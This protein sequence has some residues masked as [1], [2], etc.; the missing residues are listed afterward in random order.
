MAEIR[1]DLCPITEEEIEELFNSTDI[2]LVATCRTASCERAEQRLTAA[3]RA[4]AKYADLEIEAPALMGKRLRRLARECGT[5]FIRSFHDFET[6]PSSEDLS[7]IVQRCRRFGAEVVK[8]AVT[9]R[10]EEEVRR[11]MDLYGQAPEGTLLAFCMGEAGKRSRLDCLREGAPFTYAC[12]PGEPVADGQMSLEEMKA[13]LYGGFSFFDRQ[14]VTMPCSKSFAQR[15]IIAAALAEGTSRLEG[16]TPC[17]DSEAAIEAVRSLGAEV[18]N[19]GDSLIIKGTAGRFARQDMVSAGES[20]LLA[21]LLIPLLSLGNDRT[22]RLDGCGTLPARP[23]ADANAIMAAFGVTLSNAGY[24]GKE[25][26]VPL[27]IRGRLV[28]GRAEISGRGGSQLI[29]GLLMSLPMTGSASSLYVTGPKSI[30]YMFITVDV[31]KRFGIEMSSEMEGGDD[32][33]EARD[34]SCCTGINFNIRGGQKYRAADFPLERD[35][36]TAANFLVAGAVFGKVSVDGLDTASLQ[37]D[38]SILDILVEAGASVSQDDDGTTTGPVNVCKAPLNPFS[39]DLSNA[40][41]LFPAVS[42][43]AAFCPGTSRIGGVS[44]LS[45]KESDRAAAILEMLSG[46]GVN[47]RVEGDA[48]VIEGHSLEKRLASGNMLAGGGS[49]NPRRDHR[50]VMALKLASMG[51]GSSITIQ[52][53]DCVSKSCPF[54]ND[55]FN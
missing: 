21:R 17:G 20:G 52:D 18:H 27:D 8:I 24:G 30:P 16:Y 1:L 43:L 12:M 33:L 54:F 44:R 55:M 48:L 41:D 23:L 39:V 4:G 14:N 34:W 50:M 15:A 3:I 19:A 2:P 10:S 40:P 35:W 36:S 51:A 7:G 32:F 26:H 31:L 9:A 37:A 6:T 5:V 38:I 28:P 42:V 25:I 49:F 22:V 13:S 47:A 29:S 53:S 45:G 11:V 46:F